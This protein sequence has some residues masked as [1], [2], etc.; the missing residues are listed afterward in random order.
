MKH[1]KPE[2]IFRIWFYS[3]DGKILGKG[4]VELLELIDKTGSISAAAKEMKMSYRQAWQMVEEMNERSANPLVEKQL[5]GKSGGGTVITEAGHQAIKQFHELEK[6]IKIFI[7]Q[8][9][10]KIKV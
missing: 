9:S 10:K 7:A 2:I 6:K 4:R 3:K 8:E 5:G 1:Q